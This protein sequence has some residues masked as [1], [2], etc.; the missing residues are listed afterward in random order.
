MTI[1]VQT[2]ETPPSTTI[3]ERLTSGSG[4]LERHTPRD[5]GR[6]REAVALASNSKISTDILYRGGTP[7]K[8][9]TEDGG[10]GLT[11]AL[12]DVALQPLLSD[13]STLNDA[14]GQLQRLSA[15]SAN[16]GGT[17]TLRSDVQATVLEKLPP[18]TYPLWRRQALIIACRAVPWKYL[19][20]M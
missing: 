9:W 10:I 14:M 5:F 3:F 15:V 7:R 8:R 17:Y 18:E 20:T 4:A 19:E 12:P 11:S 13:L 2:D 6:N 1:Q 16:V